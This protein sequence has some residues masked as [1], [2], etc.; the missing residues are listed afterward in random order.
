M[1][2]AQTVPDMALNVSVDDLERTLAI[3]VQLFNR[4]VTSAQEGWFPIIKAKMRNAFLTHNPDQY[5][6]PED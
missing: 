5:L 2:L 6:M 1:E 3:A 4:N